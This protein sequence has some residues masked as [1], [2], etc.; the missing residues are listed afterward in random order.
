MVTYI[1]ELYGVQSDTWPYDYVV[2]ALQFFAMTEQNQQQYLVPD[3]PEILFHG[4]MGDYM[5][6]KAL[7]AILQISRD[8]IHAGITWTEW[9][10]D[11]TCQ[12]IEIETQFSNLYAL[13]ELSTPNNWSLNSEKIRKQAKDI[14]IS[15]GWY[16]KDSLPV[17]TCAELLNEY[18]YND[19]SAQL[20]TG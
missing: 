20:K 9:A 7:E 6:C 18:S 17:F 5:T 10:N 12:D 19:Y 3:F 8:A 2:S 16:D 1:N 14:L 13:L 15:I 11:E 4:R